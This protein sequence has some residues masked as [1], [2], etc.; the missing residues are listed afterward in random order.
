MNFHFSL[1]YMKFF[2]FLLSHHFDG[3]F[4]HAANAG[5]GFY[6]N[7]EDKAFILMFHGFNEKMET[8]IEMVLK[9]TKG[10][11]ENMDEST[12]ETRKEKMRKN[13][14]NNILEANVLE[15]NVFNDAIREDFD[16]D[17]DLLREV[18]NISF[19]DLQKFA[20]K[21]LRKLKIQVL[22]QGNLRRV[23]AMNILALLKANF[24]CEPL[25]GDS[26]K[27]IRRVYQ[28]PS[29]ETTIRMRSF[30]LNDDNSSIRNYYQFGRATVRTTSLSFLLSAVLNTK[31]FDYL[32]NK[33]QLGYQVGCSRHS[34]DGV[35]GMNVFVYSQEQKH[36]FP[37]VLEKMNFFIRE[38]A[39][40]T[41]E[42]LTDEEF[43]IIKASRIKE[44]SADIKSLY[45]EF[46]RNWNEIAEQH[47]V[48][49][50]H[51]LS[52]KVTRSITK[53]E[54]QEFFRSFTQPENMR[55]LSVQVIGNQKAEDS[56]SDSNTK[57]R[58]LNIEFMMEKTSDDENLVD[59]IEVLHSKMT[60]YPAVKFKIE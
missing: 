19:E 49:D 4:A 58:E 13:Y 42:E 54:L 26:G 14:F 27:I 3:H 43:T 38:I 6:C 35:I 56:A 25:D 31:A 50:R 39:T 9:E 21:F 41:I 51:E 32:R 7:I 47:Y 12:F 45:E 20:R 48:F 37:E 59:D 33:E 2:D 28:I 30:M 24:E 1:L 22:V 23:H 17:C 46:R 18:D 34:V 8:L 29:G 53:S 55:K 15:R 60:L 52:V 5:Y 44:L 40:K 36:P 57:Q 10:F 16:N 11:I